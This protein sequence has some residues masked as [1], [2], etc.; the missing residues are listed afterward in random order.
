MDVF[1][2]MMAAIIRV[3]YGLYMATYTSPYRQ[4]CCKDLGFKDSGV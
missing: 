1:L 2:T 3:L 4:A